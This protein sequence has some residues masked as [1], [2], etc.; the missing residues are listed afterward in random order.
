[1]RPSLINSAAG[2]SPEVYGDT[3]IL[4]RLQHDGPRTDAGISQCVLRTK[5]PE[6]TIRWCISR[7]GQGC[8]TPFTIRCVW[9]RPCSSARR[10]GLP[11]SET[12]NV[13]YHSR[14]QPTSCSQFQS[15]WDPE[16]FT[17][18]MLSSVYHLGPTTSTFRYKD[19]FRPTTTDSRGDRLWHDDANDGYDGDDNFSVLS[20]L[21]ILWGRM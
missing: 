8:T 5:R 9:A 7:R 14:V 17:I 10:Q 6:R 21:V 20:K 3:H 12:R 15:L 1:M 19:K 11:K 18:I 13:S 4:L 16:E 2:C